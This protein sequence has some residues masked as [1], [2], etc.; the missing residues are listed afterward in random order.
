MTGHIV[1]EIQ[2]F[3][4][5]D[6]M[7]WEKIWKSL[8]QMNPTHFYYYPTTKCFKLNWF[9]QQIQG[10]R[11]DEEED[12]V[13]ARDTDKTQRAVTVTN[14]TQMHCNCNRVQISPYLIRSDNTKI[15]DQKQI[16]V[17]GKGSSLVLS[18]GP[19]FGWFDK[20]TKNWGWDDT[21]RSKLRRTY[22][23]NFKF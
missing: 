21:L 22:K 20:R 13:V 10:A 4:P 16:A 3:A 9:D 6:L 15:S 12:E 18:I 14:R 19:Q 2:N 1:K 5:L 7:Q 23:Q 17:K 8:S 11:E